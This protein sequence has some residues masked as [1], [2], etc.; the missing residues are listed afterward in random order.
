MALEASDFFILLLLLL[1]LLFNLYLTRKGSLR[2]KYIFQERPCHDSRRSWLPRL[3]GWRSAVVVTGLLAATDPF[4]FSV[5]FV[6]LV[7]PVPI[8]WVCDLLPYLA[9]GTRPFVVR[10][11][12]NV[13]VVSL[14][15]FVLWTVLPVVLGWSVFWRPACLGIYIWCRIK[16]HLSPGPLCSLRLIPLYTPSQPWHVLL[17]TRSFR[18][19]L[20]S[21]YNA[22]YPSSVYTESVHAAYVT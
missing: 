2:L 9:C 14:V 22:V 11:Y 16:V 4:F 12:F 6:S 8:L 18:L 1:L 19:V 5:S 10:D 7:T 3:F 13:H 17:F 20:W 21:N 15:L